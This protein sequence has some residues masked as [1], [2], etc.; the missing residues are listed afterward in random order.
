MRQEYFLSKPTQREREILEG[1]NI[2][3]ENFISSLT[4]NW[5]V[6]KTWALT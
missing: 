3:I 2:F 5:R 4:A 1:S 6:P